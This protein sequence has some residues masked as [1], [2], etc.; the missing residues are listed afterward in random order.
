ME[1]F[2]K[3][4]LLNI[5]NVYQN[6]TNDFVNVSNK[7]INNIYFNIAKNDFK[8]LNKELVKLINNLFRDGINDDDEVKELFK[9]SKENNFKVIS[10]YDTYQIEY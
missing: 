4:D 10:K 2:T 9:R 8:N 5:I 7:D 3:K 6:Y 1:N